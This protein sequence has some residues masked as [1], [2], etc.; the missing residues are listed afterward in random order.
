[1]G[2]AER[3][4]PT[5]Q[6]LGHRLGLGV[7]I[8]GALALSACAARQPQPTAPPAAPASALPAPVSLTAPAVTD[9]VPTPGALPNVARL[10]VVQ[11]EASTERRIGDYLT[12]RGAKV[13]YETRGEDIWVVLQM[14]ADEV[15]P[16]RV[17]IDTSPSGHS[18]NGGGITERVI[19]LRLFS[20]VTILPQQRQ[21]VLA[22][23][24]KHHTRMWAGTFVI[25]EQDGEL[26][27]QWPLNITS[28]EATL[29][30]ETVYD[31][32]YRL[33]QSY[34]DLFPRLAPILSGSGGAPRPGV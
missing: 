14:S 32:W 20:G 2:T 9:A 22:E 1:M 7:S 19:L 27:A 6:R 5:T 28:P 10:G 21:A 15:P 26:E 12:Q 33:S 24:N 16:Y 30:P 8:L 4:H 31:A 13:R 34:V 3:I 29:H 25:N 11:D 18:R 17:I 23:L